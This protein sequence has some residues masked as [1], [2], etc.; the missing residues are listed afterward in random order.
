MIVRTTKNLKHLFCTSVLN[1]RAFG[2]ALVYS[3]MYYEV[4]EAIS[5]VGLSELTVS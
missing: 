3:K 5:I 1:K 4:S 2:L